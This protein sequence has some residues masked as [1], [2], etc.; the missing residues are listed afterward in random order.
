[1][2]NT[3]NNI[4]RIIPNKNNLSLNVDNYLNNFN[5]NKRKI[6]L[7]SNHFNILSNNILNNKDNIEEEKKYRKI[8][9]PSLSSNRIF[10][11]KNN[12]ITNPSSYYK[13][14]DEDYY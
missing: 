11:V 12:E 3:N 7:K 2:D 8:L 5:S 14:Y 10:S 4:Y 6:N 13:K 1:M 9:I